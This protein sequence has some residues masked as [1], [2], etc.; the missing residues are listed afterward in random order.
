MFTEAKSERDRP[1]DAV[2]FLS[3]ACPKGD[4]APTDEEGFSVAFFVAPIGGRG[5]FGRP[6]GPTGDDDDDSGDFSCVGEGADLAKSD[7]DRPG[8]PTFFS[9]AFPKNPFFGVVSGV[10]IVVS[11][12]DLVRLGIPFGPS[13]T[14]SD[15]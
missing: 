14:G 15:C 5:P 10:S 2:T 3:D 4:G 8:V 1:G 9:E 6:F 12:L 7:W 11:S 13:S